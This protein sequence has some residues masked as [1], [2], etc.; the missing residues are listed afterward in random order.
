[1]LLPDY[2][3]VKLR[4]HWAWPPLSDTAGGSWRRDPLD[5]LGDWIG[6]PAFLELFIGPIG[7]LATTHER[8][9]SGT[10]FGECSQH[11]PFRVESIGVES[12]G[13]LPLAQ[14]AAAVESAIPG[15]GGS[16]SGPE[17]DQALAAWRRLVALLDDEHCACW[18][19]IPDRRDGVGL[20]DAV[21]CER[22]EEF[23]IFD[24]LRNCVFEIVVSDD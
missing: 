20:G 23:L 21:V 11:G 8:G 10:S 17:T 14:L 18:R 24:K 4:K 16:A 19:L 13:L 2:R 22:F 9:K 3:W 5:L 1:M 7:V 15:D 12:Y 6:C